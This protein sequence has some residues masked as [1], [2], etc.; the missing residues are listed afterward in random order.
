MFMQAPMRAWNC[1]R[2]ARFLG[3]A[4]LGV[5]AGLAAAPALAQATSDAPASS[6]ATT[7]TSTGVAEVVVTA[8]RRATSL[9]KTAIAATVFTGDQLKQ[10]GIDNI[11]MLQFMTPSLSI[12]DSGV[13]V[14]INIRGIGK[15]DSG[16]EVPP[17]TLIYRDGVSVTPGGILSDEPYYDIANLE[18]LRG[19]QGTF[20]GQNAT[21]GALFITETD[22]QLG[23]FG[24]F[25]EGQYGNYNDTRLQAAVNIPIGDDFALRIATDDEHRDTFFH[26]TG[27][28]TGNQ[29]NLGLAAVRVSALWQPTD[30]FKAVLKVDYMYEDESHPAGVFDGV[31]NIFNVAAAGDLAGLERQ[32][33]TVLQLSYRF[34]NGI[35]V[36]SI[37]GYQVGTV[38]AQMDANG[39]SNPLLLETFH[40]NSTDQTV[41]QEI[42][43]LSPDTGRFQWVAG[44]IYQSDIVSQP[45]GS[46]WLSLTPGANLSSG[47]TI[48]LDEYRASKD[49]WGVFG[50]GTYAITDRLKLQVGARYSE[51]SFRLNS[52]DDV[53]LYGYP[54]LGQRIVGDSEHDGRLTGKVNLDWTVADNNFLYAFVATGHKGGGINGLGTLSSIT[55][56][57]P[58]APATPAQLPTQFGP[59]DVIDYEVGW[60]ANLFDNH[61]H[62]QLGGFYYDYTNFQVVF[63]EPQVAAG[64]DVNAPGHTRID[65]LEAQAQGQ[66]G[67]WSFDLGGSYLNSSIANISAID[68]RNPGA[69]LVDLDGRQQPYAPRFTAQA[70]VQYTLHVPGDATLT[71]RLDYGYVSSQWATLFEVRSTDYLPAYDLFNAQLIYQRAN[72]WRFTLYA[73]NLFDEH[74]VSAQALANLAI[75]GPP[76]Q[77]GVRVFKSF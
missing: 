74:Y 64:I 13:G 20:A 71:P 56:G 57:Q 52:L 29:G 10:R 41:S 4:A 19:P 75:P 72:N 23:Q 58:L 12:Q 17:G 30:A 37:S 15:S 68:S 77:F 27:P 45:D 9:Q 66:W 61:V 42:N 33:R 73:T 63:Y 36:R 6:Q 18:V 8:E 32:I 69:G 46:N 38:S 1:G 11:D 67:P 49:S 65:G 24:G 22:P 5:I 62:T 40:T 3:G 70:G 44:A 31:A 47:E 76:R 21:G 2:A 35:T 14:L 28:Y 59:E 48:V 34:D 60:K 55:P 43:I 39:T 16:Q 25:A 54:A 51:S 26:L 7:A 53:L 50:Q